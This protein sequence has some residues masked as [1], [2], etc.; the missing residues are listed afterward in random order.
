[1]EK[2]EE[3]GKDCLNEIPLAKN[4]GGFSWAELLG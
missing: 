1:M 2:N 4:D 3:V